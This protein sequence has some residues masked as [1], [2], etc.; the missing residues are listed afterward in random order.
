MA[1]RPKLAIATFHGIGSYFDRYED[2]ALRYDRQLQDGLRKRLGGDFDS[3]AWKAVLWSAQKLER[4]QQE[5][6]RR[7]RP[8]RLWKMLFEFVSANLCDATAYRL[9]DRKE[10][11]EESSY[12]VVQKMVREALQEL[13]SEIGKAADE[14]PLLCI[15][16]S[17]GCR[18]LSGYAWDV[19]Q[20]RERIVGKGGDPASLTSFQQLHTLAGLVYTGCNLP[21]LTMDVE[22]NALM[23]MR[24]PRHPL[25]HDRAF[26]A[27]WLNFYD[28]DDVLGYPIADQYA[29]YFGGKH[30]HRERFEGWGRAPDA[31]QAPRDR[32]V[33]VRHI[34]GWTPLAHVHYWKS[35]V[36]LDAIAGEVRRLLNA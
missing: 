21:L 10:D 19:A 26:T 13:E 17:M 8:P 27:N 3:I 22:Q 34:L 16:E 25:P 36:V 12:F 20:D 33:R 29:A 31:E 23:P 14:T 2:A 1:G 32:Q 9:P 15:A 4:R 35:G 28:D 30:P 24:L 11:Y 18:V 5:L 7:R 6:I